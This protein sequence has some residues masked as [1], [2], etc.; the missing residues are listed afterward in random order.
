MPP[1]RSVAYVEYV[2]PTVAKN[3]F[4]NLSYKR[5]HNMPLYI[6]YAPL[7]IKSKDIPATVGKPAAANEKKVVKEL[8]PEV[9]VDKVETEFAT[10]FVKNLNFKTTVEDIKSHLVHVL[11]C[12]VEDDI[13][14][15]VIPTK[16]MASSKGTGSNTVQLSM[17]Y[18]F[19][20]LRSH[21]VANK[22]LSKL[23]NSVLDGHKLE[24]KLSDKKLG[25]SSTNK[26]ATAQ[27]KN[28]TETPGGIKPTNKIVIRNIAFQTNLSEIKNLCSVYGNIKNIRLP[29]KIINANNS[30]ANQH[31]GFVFVEYSTKKEAESAFQQLQNIHFYGRHLV[32]EYASNEME[33]LDP[34][35]GA[36]QSL[37]SNTLNHDSSLKRLRDKAKADMKMIE[38]MNGSK[39]SKMEESDSVDV[40]T[41]GSMKG[42]DDLN[43]A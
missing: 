43:E 1:N 29:K 24:S 20:E 3:A 9:E 36:S 17:G 28:G 22:V 13:R 2:E 25:A 40:Y 18:G 23:N 27:T 7:S 37:V 41:K 14:V 39:R 35:V 33:H 21:S 12:C 38:M 19:I 6:E 42:G 31:R 26:R 4:K 8:V 34:A 16:S 32:C 10:I 30:T 15:I 5:Y 11:S